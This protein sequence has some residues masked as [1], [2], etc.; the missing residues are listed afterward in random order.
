MV[1]RQSTSGTQPIAAP[2]AKSSRA[3]VFAGAAV[4]LALGALVG[5]FFL[6]P[7]PAHDPPASTASTKPSVTVMLFD[8][9]NN[10]PSLDWLRMG[11]TEML[12]TDLSQSPNIDVL[13]TN[14]LYQILEELNRQDDRVTSLGVIQKVIKRA[15][16]GTVIV[17][18]FM[19]AGE[20]IRINIRIQDASSGKILTT[21]KIEG[22]GE[23]SIFSMVE[24]AIEQ[25]EINKRLFGPVLHCTGT[26]SFGYAALGRLDEAERAV[27]DFVGANSTIARGHGLLAEHFARAGKLEEALAA[28]RKA[29]SLDPSERWIEAVRVDVFILRE[30]WEDARSAAERMLASSNHEASFVGLASLGHV[31]LFRGDSEKALELFEENAAAHPDHRNLRAAAHNDAANVLI[32][33][34]EPETALALAKTARLAGESDRPEWE[35]LYWSGLARARLS[36]WQE[37]GETAELLRERPQTLPTEKAERRLHHLTG[38][39]ALAKGETDTA[40]EELTRAQAML[41]PRGARYWN[42]PPH[43]PI[44]FSLGSA[45]FAAGN[46]HDAAELLQRIVDSTTEHTA[47]PIPYVRSCY[48]L[49]KIHENQG[50]LDKA[51]QYYRRFVDFWKDGDMDRERVK[52]AMG[53]I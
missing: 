1:M 24:N 21:E 28:A 7:Q 5:W 50:D 12:V 38:E 6:R 8:N 35:A 15:D 40:V 18:S 48:F 17:G 32:E 11:L 13:S 9:I 29:E 51:R 25:C 39:L 52:E 46:H 26:L 30:E 33:R 20:N 47:W 43:V 16:A 42:T 49:G 31:A 19:K 34:G 36:Q 3:P 14:R 4:L 10:D 44:W 22:V 41:A 2:H 45:H 27:Q 53:K 37:A 23:D